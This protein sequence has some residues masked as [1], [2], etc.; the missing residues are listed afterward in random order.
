MHIVT[1]SRLIPLLAVALVTTLP[2]FAANP[3][4]PRHGINDP[5]V[6]IHDGKAYLFASHDR[7][8]ENKSFVMDDWRIYS[9]T[10]LVHWQPESI[11]TPNMTYL[12]G[13]FTGCWAPDAAFRNGQWYFYFSEKNQRAGVLVSDSIKG[14]WRDP[15][16]GP[17]LNSDLT[18]TDEYDMG[19]LQDDDGTAYIV[20]G[21]WEYYIARLNEDM[22]SLAEKPRRITLDRNVGPYGDGKTDDKPYLHK[23]N[24]KY[25]LSWGCFY[26]T[27]D[28]PYGPYTYRGTCMNKESFAPGYAEPTWPNGPLQ[29]R[30]GAFF[31]WHN[32]WYFIYCDI[33]QTGNRFFRDSFISYVHYRANGEI[34]PVRVDGVGVGEYRLD[35][36]PIEAE[37]Y[38]KSVGFQ[39]RE[40][41]DG[42][43]FGVVVGPG[44]GHVVYPNIWGLV[45]CGSL[46]LRA[47]VPGQ[48]PVTVELRETGPGGRQI[49]QAVLAPTGG[50]DRMQTFPV[51]FDLAPETETLCLVFPAKSGSE[52]VLDSFTPKPTL[53]K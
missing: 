15:L 36:G 40:H 14:P 49:G 44:G 1:P 31:E 38:F 8:I 4:I 28:T 51:T 42:S 29:G 18:P 45:T 30:H 43:G 53:A 20:F 39:K 21:V 23:A 12:R 19:I 47:A 9:S 27:A 35:N 10:D 2:G 25:Y 22:I 37:N 32:Q 16:G 46:D 34:A 41:A 5:H 11:I 50:A 33:S 6:R 7:S 3:V 26:A 17:L 52:V 24:G 13:P 48:S